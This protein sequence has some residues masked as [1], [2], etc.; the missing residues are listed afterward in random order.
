[1]AFSGIGAF[2]FYKRIDPLI[3]SSSEA[4]FILAILLVEVFL[5]PLLKIRGMMA[6][7]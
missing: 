5:L 2:K 3:R 1:M 6:Y 7:D 4:S